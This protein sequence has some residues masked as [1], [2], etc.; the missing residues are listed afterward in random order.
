MN[1]VW[2]EA[3]VRTAR[4]VS[5]AIAVYLLLCR[6]A[7]AFVPVCSAAQIVAAEGCAPAPSTADCTIAGDYVTSQPDCT[8]D[9]GNRHVLINGTSIIDA[10]SRRLTIRAGRLT[11]RESAEIRARGDATSTAGGNINLITTGNLTLERISD[12]IVTSGDV[13][14]SIYVEAGGTVTLSGRLSAD[15]S[16]LYAVGG[17]ISVVAGQDILVRSTGLITAKN[18]AEAFS[19]GTIELYTNNGRIEVSGTIT[20]S[21]GEGGAIT[22]D[23]ATN[24]TTTV[25]IFADGTGNGGNGGSIEIFAGTGIDLNGRLLARGGSG[26]GGFGGGAGGTVF[27]EADFGDLRIRKNILADGAV[28]DADG[29][30]IA[31]E[32]NGSIIVDSAATIS[33]GTYGSVGAAG[34]LSLDATV[35]IL[36]SGTI[37]AQGGVE[38]GEIALAA[39]RNIFVKALDALGRDAGSYGGTIDVQAGQLTKGILTIDGTLNSSGG[40]C[41]T[42]E[43]CGAGGIQLLDGCDVVLTTNALLRNRGADGGD[44]SLI[45]RGRLTIQGSARVDA[46]TTVGGTQGS[47]GSNSLSHPVGVPPSISATATI[48]PAA[49]IVAAAIGVCPTCGNNVIEEGETCDD[50]NTAGCDGCSFSCRIQLCDDGN[51]CTEDSCDPTFGC[52]YQPVTNGVACNDGLNCTSGDACL[53]GRCTGTQMDCSFLDTACVRGV[54]NELTLQCEG[55]SAPDGSACDDGLFCTVADRCN[56]GVCGGQ[57]RDCSSQDGICTA[58]V[59]DEDA[60]RCEAQPANEGAACDDG[61]PCTLNDVCTNGLCGYPASSNCLCITGCS[62]AI[63]CYTGVDFCLASTCITPDPGCEAFIFPPCC[64]NGQVDPGEQCDDG[65]N[66]ET[67]GCTSSCTI[68]PGAPASP[69]RTPTGAASATATHSPTPSLTFSAT[70]TPTRTPTFTPTRTATP[71][72]SS[73]PTRTPTATMTP[74]RTA[75]LTPTR[76]PTAGVTAT[77]TS[78]ATPSPTPFGGCPAQ[79][80]PGCALSGKAVVAAKK[81]GDPKGNQLVFQW[82]RGAETVAADLGSPTTGGNYHLCAY[83]NAGLGI[84]LGI[85]AASV[86]SNGRACWSIVGQPDKVKGYRYRDSGRV[87]DGVQTVLLASG[88]EGY[89]KIAVKAKG[90]RLRLPGLANLAL[91]LRVQ[92]SSDGGECWEAEI[93]GVSVSSAL[94][95]LTGRVEIAPPFRN[96]GVSSD[97]TQLYVPGCGRTCVRRVAM[98]GGTITTSHFAGILLQSI[99]LAPDGSPLTAITQSGNL[100]VL[101]GALDV[102]RD[103]SLGVA[104]RAVDLAPDGDGLALLEASPSRDLKQV[105]VNTGAVVATTQLAALPYDVAALSSCARCSI[106]TLPALGVVQVVRDGV[107]AEVIDVGTSPRHVASNRPASGDEIAV[108]TSRAADRVTFVNVTAAA[109]TGTLALR[110]PTDADALPTLAFVLFENDSRLAVVS[111]QPGPTF[112]RL[113]AAIAF[114]Q[115]L[116]AVRVARGTG[117]A[118]VVARTHDRLWK[119]DPAQLPSDGSTVAAPVATLIH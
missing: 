30:E 88:D 35:D 32:S 99:D 66:I 95:R 119:I 76:T 84:A 5:C 46:T 98:P 22:I 80:A 56:A 61:Q 106:V 93:G 18:G 1:A 55:Q 97:G 45:A 62:C 109:V 4:L 36:A 19:P 73:T 116:D 111:L 38:G 91:G 9:F 33:G 82:L 83:S 8:L 87:H 40:I 65:N 112:G 12:V 11:L 2:W 114:P 48:V 67:D 6:A 89:A 16:T 50:G 39:G 60:D 26:S 69:T 29:A 31:I 21:G 101:G 42:L 23:A 7:A 105:D 47:D 53:N 17:T 43:G 107:A 86:C 77:A 51:T 85:P 102:V 49:T 71:T 37:A 81:P 74:T 113:L 90:E 70:R 63:A 34:V 54:C 57:P 24:V 44:T 58:G 3:F 103:V 78:T 64:G 25:D 108:V 15:G 100:R 59:C 72:P 104:V 13:A 52:R 92:V 14:G 68:G 110:N 117:V 118:Y 27:L 10:G 75:S 115:R 41:G 20:S 79:P 28:P 96:V 94:D